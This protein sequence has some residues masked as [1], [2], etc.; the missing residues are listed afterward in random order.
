[1]SRDVIKE[2]TVHFRGETKVKAYTLGDAQRQVISKKH[3]VSDDAIHVESIWE[4]IGRSIVSNIGA[5]LTLLIGTAFVISFTQ[6]FSIVQTFSS[7]LD[8]F[9]I[10]L[11]LVFLVSVIRMPV[12]VG[13]WFDTRWVR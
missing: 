8:M 3:V 9:G 2:F 12:L 4:T 13:S 1:M 7:P 10:I 5:I 11:V 6:L